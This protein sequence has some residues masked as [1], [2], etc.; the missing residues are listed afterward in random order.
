MLNVHVILICATLSTNSGRVNPTYHVCVCNYYG[1][2]KDALNFALFHCCSPHTVPNV[3]E[4]KDTRCGGKHH[5]H[6]SENSSKVDQA[7]RSHQQEK[8]GTQS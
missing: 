7:S 8:Q 5:T 6:V 4:Y 2:V 3:C 1:N